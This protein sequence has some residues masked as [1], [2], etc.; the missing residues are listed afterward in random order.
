VEEA[1][2][3]LVSVSCRTGREAALTSPIKLLQVLAAS[4]LLRLRTTALS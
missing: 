1:E 4:E 3:A 2:E